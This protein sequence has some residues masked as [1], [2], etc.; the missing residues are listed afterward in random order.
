[1]QQGELL[2]L[3]MGGEQIALDPVGKKGQGALTGLA[4]FDA[5]ALLD[6]TLGDP[7]RQ[8]AALDRIDT[9]ADA[10]AVQ[11]LE[12]GAVHLRLVQL[13]QGDQG[14]HIFG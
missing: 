3:L 2:Q 9:H 12:P 10:G 6:Q 7:L 4:V 8:G 5:L 1:V 13:G 14:H 11:G